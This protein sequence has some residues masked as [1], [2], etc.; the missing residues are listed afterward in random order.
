MLRGCL[1]LYLTGGLFGNF[2]SASGAACRYVE[3]VRGVVRPLRDGCSRSNGARCENGGDEVRLGVR[4]NVGLSFVD[5]LG[6]VCSGNFFGSRRR[7]GV[8]GGRIFRA[9]YRY[10][11]VSLSGFRGSLSHS[12]A[13]DAT[14]RGRLGIVRSLGSW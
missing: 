1:A 12:L 8:D 14:L 10:L 6:T 11:G 9:F 7:G 2:Y 5:L 13:S 4:G 3:R